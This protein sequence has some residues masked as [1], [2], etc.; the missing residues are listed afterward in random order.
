MGREVPGHRVA[1]GPATSSLRSICRGPRGFRISGAV[2]ELHEAGGRASNGDFIAAVGIIVARKSIVES[3]G[4][5]TRQEVG[6]TGF[7][8]LESYCFRCR[9][10]F[11]DVSFITLFQVCFFVVVSFLLT[12][13]PKWGNGSEI[14]LSS[15]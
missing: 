13:G 15:C 4:T 1:S 7:V 11:F 5:R 9:P 12:Q 6:E 8:F 10:D 14:I 3:D 2:L